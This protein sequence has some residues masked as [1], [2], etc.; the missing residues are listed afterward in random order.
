MEKSEANTEEWKKYEECEYLRKRKITISLENIKFNVHDPPILFK[1]PM[2]TYFIYQRYSGI[3]SQLTQQGTVIVQNSF[4]H[5]VGD[6]YI[7]NHNFVVFVKQNVND[8]TW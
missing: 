8:R 1:G 7:L 3:L 2:S 6:V 4:M 5:I